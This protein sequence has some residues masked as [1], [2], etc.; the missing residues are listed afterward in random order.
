MPM[1]DHGRLRAAARDA[2]VDF[3]GHQHRAHRRIAGGQPLRDGHQVRIDLLGL[4]REQRAGAAEA[5][6][7]LV[8]DEQ[9]AEAPACVA[10]R[11]QPAGRRHDHAAGALH[12]LAEE[13]GDV[14]R[15]ELR[16]LR[17]E[18]GDRRGD[19]RLRIVAERVAIRVGRRNM[20]LVRAR[21][22][23]MAVEHGQRGEPRADRRRA[24]I[25][26][27]E[28]DH[29]LLRRA[30]GRVEIVGDEAQR[31]IDRIRAAEREVH[32]VQRRRRERREPFGELDR[33]LRAEMEIAGRVGQLLH[34]LGGGL[35]DAVAAVADVH[36]PQARERIEQRMA[37]A[38]AQEHAVSGFEHGDAARLVRAIVDDGVDQVLTIGFDQRGLVHGRAGLSS[39]V[40]GESMLPGEKSA[41][42]FN[43]LP[44]TYGRGVCTGRFG[45]FCCAPRRAGRT[46][47]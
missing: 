41:R 22:V 30:A 18:R 4:A 5:G 31:G 29:L 27:L 12:G 1:T 13:C 38:V 43:L 11:L 36:A 16:D 44:E 21:Y 34:L 24:V 46:R 20:V 42:V 3:V 47:Q 10:H 40:S 25:A 9:D 37:V 17:F 26:A 32:A 15:A 39:G 33:G 8:G 35:H 2:F 23:E 6:D 45:I 19:Q 28:R 14:V 7:D